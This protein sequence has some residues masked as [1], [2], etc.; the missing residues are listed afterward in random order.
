[1][2]RNF[3]TQ[4]MME[5]IVT[6]V[7]CKA[8]ISPNWDGEIRAVNVE[9]IINN[10]YSI[11]FEPRNLDA[12]ADDK[13][14]VYAAICPEK[15]VIYFNESQWGFLE[16]RPGIRNFTEAHELGHWILHCDHNA[17]EAISLFGG[18]TMYCRGINGSSRNPKEIQADMFA[19]ALLMPKDIITGAINEIKKVRSISFPDL[20]SMRDHFEVTISALCNRAQSLGL[21]V[22]KDNKVYDN[23]VEAMQETK[24]I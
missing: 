24:L 3:I 11:D 4:G 2:S 22:I 19:A 15:K 18:T 17:S 23:K 10:T 9:D 16:K 7:L 5:R 14:K 20:Y 21:I 1:M 12:Y 6:D 13:S 8:K